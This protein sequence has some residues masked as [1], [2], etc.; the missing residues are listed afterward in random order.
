MCE[1]RSTMPR[2]LNKPARI[3]SLT[4]FLSIFLSTFFACVRADR[5]CCEHNEH[6]HACRPPCL[7]VFLLSATWRT[8]RPGALP[9]WH[10]GAARSARLQPSP[11][12]TPH[13]G[14]RHVKG[15][16]FDCD[17]RDCRK[18]SESSDSSF[19]CDGL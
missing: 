17:C 12:H 8:A 19:F 16:T 15:G 10:G 5:A 6:G 9:G 2:K 18:R 1:W 3:A 13:A 7:S 14:E 11:A 4:F